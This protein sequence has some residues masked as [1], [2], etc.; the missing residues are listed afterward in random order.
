MLR[1]NK[2]FGKENPHDLR[3]ITNISTSNFA[4]QQKKIWLSLS[5]I[6]YV[7]SKMVQKPRYEHLLGG[8]FSEKISEGLQRAAAFCKLR[9]EQ[10]C[11]N[12]LDQIILQ[13]QN[14]ET[15]DRRF[16]SDLVVK[17]RTKTAALLYAQGLSLDTSVELT[18]AERNEVLSYSGKTMMPDRMGKTLSA[19]ERLAYARKLV[20]GKGKQNNKG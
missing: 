7:L 5:L 16:I 18:G 2:A 11:Q 20:K 15:K 14:M 8:K 3:E 13:I 9:K 6:S 12:E 17:G 10:E 19:R 1:L 4:I